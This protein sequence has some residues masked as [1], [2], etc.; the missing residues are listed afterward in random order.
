MDK[1]SQSTT[2][3][4]LIYRNKYKKIKL[5]QEQKPTSLKRPFYICNSLLLPKNSEWRML[6]SPTPRPCPCD[7][8]ITRVWHLG[9]MRLRRNQFIFTVQAKT[10]LFILA[11]RRKRSLCCKSASTAQPTKIQLKLERENKL[12]NVS[13]I[14]PFWIIVFKM[15]STKQRKKDSHALLDE[16]FKFVSTHKL[17]RS[18]SC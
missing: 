18:I 17:Y 16:N 4:N 10:L 13:C 5:Q 9:F 2:L 3:Q 12:L 8:H 11:S 7:P 1:L 15:S 14:I 6:F